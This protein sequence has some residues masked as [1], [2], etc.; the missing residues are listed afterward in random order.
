MLLRSFLF[1]WV[2]CV[3][4]VKLTLWLQNLSAVFN[5]H[6]RDL[7]SWFLHN[8]L[9]LTAPK[10]QHSLLGYQEMAGIPSCFHVKDSEVKCLNVFWWNILI[11][12]NNETYFFW[13]DCAFPSLLHVW[14]LVQECILWTAF[15]SG[16][17]GGHN[18]SALI[19]LSS[20][21]VMLGFL[22]LERKTSKRQTAH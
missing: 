13:F 14:M 10:I 5:Q 12:H 11:L 9:I 7:L 16:V 18:R 4:H 6:I 21:W 2:W 20:C 1:V 8:M 22:P 19:T 17:S 3:M 15:I